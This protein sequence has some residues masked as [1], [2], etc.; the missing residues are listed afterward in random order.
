MR[1]FAIAYLEMDPMYFRSGYIKALLLEKLKAVDFD[2][3]E[4]ARLTAV[5][6]D[7]VRTR[8]QREFRRYCKLAAVLQSPEVEEE[9]KCL[10]QSSDGRVASRAKMM[11]QYVQTA[12]GPR[13][14]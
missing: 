13:S 7:A 5:L 6:I 8:G 4:T 2:E 1:E 12:R 11:L 10:A 14:P 3:P 9:A